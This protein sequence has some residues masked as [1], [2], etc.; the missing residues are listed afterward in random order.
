MLSRAV[1]CAIAITALALIASSFIGAV[2]P[3]A[4]DSVQNAPV[5]SG[6]GQTAGPS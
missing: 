2:A 5:R 4:A 1:I 6:G 3:D